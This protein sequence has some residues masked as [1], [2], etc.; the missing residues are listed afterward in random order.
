[1]PTTSRE[2]RQTPTPQTGR[3]DF[4]FA[5]VLTMPPGPDPMDPDD[6]DARDAIFGA[7]CD[8]A[9][10]GRSCGVLSLDFTREAES[11]ADAVLSAIADVRSAGVL[12]LDVVR[13]EPDDLVTL[14]QVAARV[15]RSREG[16]RLYAA[17]SRGPGGFPAPVSGVRGRSPLYR[18]SEVARWLASNV[19]GLDLGGATRSPTP[20]RSGPS[21]RRWSCVGWRRRAWRR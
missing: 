2:L 1:M 16:L 12:G 9:S 3:R 15:G 13:V 17:G 14:G 7:G 6:P 10:L 8:D 20:R 21:T 19:P 5:L 18:W 11:L 4:S